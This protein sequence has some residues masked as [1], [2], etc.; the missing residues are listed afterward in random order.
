MMKKQGKE[1]M[2]GVEKY[3]IAQTLKVGTIASTKL[4]HQ[5]LSLSN[6]YIAQTSIIQLECFV[7]VKKQPVII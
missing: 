1:Q 2:K 7:L 4:K 3:Y 6:K 5:V